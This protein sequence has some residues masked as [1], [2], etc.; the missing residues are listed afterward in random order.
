MNYAKGVLLLCF[1]SIQ[2][3]KREFI[4]G[5]I[6]KALEKLKTFKPKTL[7]THTLIANLNFFNIIEKLYARSVAVSQQI[8][9]A[10]FTIK[11]FRTLKGKQLFDETENEKENDNEVVPTYGGINID[12]DNRLAKELKNVINMWEA[13]IEKNQVKYL[14]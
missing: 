2:L 3:S 10:N 12:E 1:H 13:C 6:T 11:A 4:L 9:E 8:E 5:F 7:T 14:S